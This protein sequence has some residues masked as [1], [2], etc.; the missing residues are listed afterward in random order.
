M[1]L[2]ACVSLW[3]PVFALL[4]LWAGAPQLTGA[5]QYCLKG[6]VY[7]L[8]LVPNVSV[9]LS[10]FAGDCTLSNNVSLS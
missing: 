2:S 9:A 10:V 3:P 7:E 6:A 8:E 1:V 5:S 4:Y